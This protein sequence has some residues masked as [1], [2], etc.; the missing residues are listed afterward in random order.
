MLQSTSWT[1]Q[2]NY[3]ST[4]YE[5]GQDSNCF[6]SMELFLPIET[7]VCSSRKMLLGFRSLEEKHS[8]GK[9]YTNPLVMLTY[10]KY[11]LWAT[12]HKNTFRFLSWKTKHGDINVVNCSARL[13]VPAEQALVPH[14]RDSAGLN[15]HLTLPLVSVR[16]QGRV[17]QWKSK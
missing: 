15:T 4:K 13:R 5:L 12:D 8:N 3:N 9:R 1:K 17:T 14:P 6:Q 7:F 2:K 16:R 10:S 11:R